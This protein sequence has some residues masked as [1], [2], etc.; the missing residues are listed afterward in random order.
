MI[1]DS[2]EYRNI[3]MR[4][5]RIEKTAYRNLS[6]DMEIEFFKEGMEAVWADVQKRAGEFKDVSDTDIMNYFIKRFGV[7]K[8]ELSKRCI[9]MKEKSTSKYIGT[10]IAWFEPK[11]NNNVS[12]VH[13]L[14]VDD[15]Y[16]GKGYARMLITQVLTIF[17]KFGETD[18][19]YL[20]TQPCSYRAIKLYNDFGF[21]MCKKDTYGTTM[22]EYAEAIEILKKHMTEEAFHKLVRT[23]V[24]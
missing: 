11:R 18:R 21:C 6:S 8:S 4:C 7:S 9:F 12:V 20:H 15:A 2:I 13:W 3:I 24:E 10:C 14:A 19:I 5:D 23:S 17:E 1:D 22:N 16:A